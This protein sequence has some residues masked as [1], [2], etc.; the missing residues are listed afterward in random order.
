MVSLT[1]RAH[2]FSI[3]AILFGLV[4]ACGSAALKP[5]GGGG[6]KGG[7]DASAGGSSGSAGVAGGGGGVGGA[8]GDAACTCPIEIIAETVCGLDGNTYSSAC[9]AGCAGVGVAHQ[10][11]CT[12]AGADAARPLRYCDTD[13]DCELRPNPCCGGTCAA[14][15]DPR[16]S[17]GPAPIC[18]NVACPVSSNSCVCTNHS[19]VEA[20]ACA[21]TGGGA[22]QS[23]PNGYL[24]GPGGCPTCEC[25]PGDGGTDGPACAPLGV[26][27]VNCP[28]G[29][30]TG[31]G[32]CRTCACKP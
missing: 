10:G 6:G 22:C 24:T 4:S 23:C 2:A 29:Y 28:N 9:R 17:P 25:A 31:P 19:C 1:A 21:P 26:L 13:M 11:A 7:Q 5:D 18:N 8:G 27:C 3:S 15:T 30:L 16:P 14:G 32:G 20:P 12:D